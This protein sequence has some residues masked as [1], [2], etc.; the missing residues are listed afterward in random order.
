MN[1]TVQIPYLNVLRLLATFAVVILHSSATYLN[2][3]LVSESDYNAFSFYNVINVYA[4]PIFVMISGTLFLNPMKETGFKILLTKYVKRIALALFV[5]GLP[6]CFVECVLSGDSLGQAFI[7]FI[8]GNS[9]SHMWYLYMLIGLYL[10]TPILKPFVTN[11]DNSSLLIAFGVLFIMCSI[12]PYFEKYGVGFNSSGNGWMIIKNNPYI[13]LY[14]LGFYI[15]SK[16]IKI[17]KKT[18]WI[19]FWGIL[20]IFLIRFFFGINDFMYYDPVA[21][22]LS[23]SLFLLFKQLNLSWNIADKLA[24]YC[25]GIYLT[26]PFFYNILSKVLH[27]SP[28]DYMEAWVSIPLLGCLTFLA[29]L[30]LCY[31]MRKIPFLTKYV[32]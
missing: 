9:W 20:C 5:F 13:L 2:N 7:N 6:M 29:S 1:K 19:V 14:M 18:S 21:I 15:S 30:L 22:L 10:L 16:E 11:S 32:L 27:I 8:T 23:A 28:A 31:I 25:F 3:G 12:M 17:S 24:P 4:V 26:H